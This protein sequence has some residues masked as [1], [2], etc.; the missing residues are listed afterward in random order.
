MEQMID[1]VL[2]KVKGNQTDYLLPKGLS[3]QAFKEWKLLNKDRIEDL[4]GKP[5]H[6]VETDEIREEVITLTDVMLN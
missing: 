1:G 5:I 4:K 3:G 2:V 6:F